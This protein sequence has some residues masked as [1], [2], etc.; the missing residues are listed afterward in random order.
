VDYRYDGTDVYGLYLMKGV[1]NP[2]LNDFVWAMYD[3]LDPGFDLSFDGTAQVT[4]LT[5]DFDPSG[6][7]G[8]V[9]FTADITTG[10]L[11]VLMPAF[12]KTTDGGDTWQGPIVADLNSM[13][14]VL[15]GLIPGRDTATTGFDADIAVDA[16]GNPHYTILVASGSDYSITTGPGAYMKI[17]D[18]TYN[19]NNALGCEWQAI[20][21]DSVRT[22]RG[23][24]TSSITADNRCHAATSPDGKRVFFG[25]TDSNPNLVGGTSNDLPD[26]KTRAINLETRLAT[27]TINW[28]YDDQTWSGQALFP[29]GSPTTLKS[30]NTYT[31]P[32]IFTALN[33]SGS[34]LDPT[35]FHYVQDIEFTEA[36]FVHDIWP[37]VITLNG[38]N[39]LSVLQGGTFNDPGA[40]ATDN[41]DG[42]ISG[43]ISTS[44]TVNTSTV[45]AYAVTYTVTDSAGNMSCPVTRVVNVLASPDT[46]PPVITLLGPDTIRIDLCDSTYSE[47]G[48]TATDDVDGNITHNIMTSDN[49]QPGVPGAYWVMYTVT[50]GASNADTAYR[51]VILEDLPPQITLLGND[52]VKVEICFPFNDPGATASDPCLGNVPVT[53]TGSV[54]TSTVG[55]YVL[56]YVAADSF[57]ADTAMRVVNV[58]PDKTAP[59]VTLV[60]SA[61]EKICLGTNYVDS[62]AVAMDCVDGDITGSIVK[63]GSV[64]T[65]Q[66]GTYHITYVSTDA[67]GNTDSVNRTVVVNTQ[68]EPAWGYSAS[69]L[70]VTFT[71]SSLYNPKNWTWTFGDGNQSQV[72]NPTHIYQATGSYVVCLEVSNDFNQVCN[73]SPLTNCDTIMVEVG[74]EEVLQASFDVYPNPTDGEVH[75]VLT[76]NLFAEMTVSVTNILGEVV[77]QPAQVQLVGQKNFS[78][79][80]SNQSEGIY[81]IN[82]ETN[83]GTLTERIS[84]TREQR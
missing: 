65:S 16:W 79:D 61:T 17:Y 27:D 7:Y 29:A 15:A 71:D 1:W 73:Q 28:T 60:G 45:G 58:T 57:Q 55:T 82:I 34:D 9:G 83:K 49:I 23:D 54:D 11:N 4:G 44:G 40:T 48:A 36:S 19:G 5:M 41:N 47:P 33:P 66:R 39:P 24:L 12:Y 35:S 3:T 42:N 13:P 80:L 43:S 10:G 70:T 50:D 67:A 62:G 31:W 75:I 22:F 37:P 74:I 26:W 53:V 25:W 46:T 21:I 8:W 59:T 78:I 6:Q 30:G 68:P 20:Y 76:N 2:T 52:T 18:I 81:F 84:L 51:T 64:N 77:Y 72:Q 14:N 32:T 63:Q 56:W 69:N 38:P